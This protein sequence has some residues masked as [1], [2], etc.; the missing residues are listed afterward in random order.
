MSSRRSI[1]IQLDNVNIHH[2]YSAILS[3]NFS[4]G[5]RN[6]SEPCRFA[7]YSSI[8]LT[9][10][11][12]FTVRYCYTI[13]TVETETV[14]FDTVINV[15]FNQSCF[16]LSSQLNP[17]YSHSLSMSANPLSH[18]IMSDRLTIIRTNVT[19]I[20]LFCTKTNNKFTIALFGAAW[21]CMILNH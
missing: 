18:S 4:C 11:V 20:T 8:L 6:R 7:R 17:Q 13:S 9:L 21:S 16:T 3:Y 12:D 15:C 14:Q 1:P 10:V 19:W 2:L 5:N